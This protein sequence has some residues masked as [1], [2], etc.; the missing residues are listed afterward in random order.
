MAVW[1]RHAHAQSAAT[2]RRVILVRAARG[3]RAEPVRDPSGV[4]ATTAARKTPCLVC[5]TRVPTSRDSSKGET[6]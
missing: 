6:V 2:A 4:P 5:V 3:A 1:I